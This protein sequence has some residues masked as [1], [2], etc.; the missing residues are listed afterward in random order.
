MDQVVL[1]PLVV[2]ALQLGLF[3][4]MVSV[5]LETARA[6]WVQCFDKPIIFLVAITLQIICIPLLALI[7]VQL[8]PMHP[9]VK[10]GILLISLCPGG[11]ISNY[12]TS[13]AG[14]NVALSSVLTLISSML[15]PFTLPLGLYLFSVIQ[16][17][18]KLFFNVELLY[19]TSWLTVIIII[20]A[21]IIGQLLKLY[22]KVTASIL[23]NPLKLFSFMLISLIIVSALV[24]NRELLFT[25]FLTLFPVAFVFNAL[26]LLFGFWVGRFFKQPLAICKT[27]SMELG[28]QN[29]G[30]AMIIAPS[31]FPDSSG[32]LNTAAFWGV[33]HLTSGLSLSH[34]WHKSLRK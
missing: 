21:L 1:T 33:W 24:K 26:L 5:S 22:F 2:L 12:F 17:E 23:A 25:E 4:M 18:F 30:V 32:V 9:E 7:F 11:V 14:G 20:P 34:Y 19:K 27:L 10:M 16:P 13:K 28:I 29:I 8:V 3:I 31:L 6:D 15:V